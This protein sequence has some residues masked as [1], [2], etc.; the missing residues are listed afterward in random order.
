MTGEWGG[1]H[2][3]LKLTESGGTLIYDCAAGTMDGPLRLD[4]DGRF[5]AAGLHTPA[6]AEPEVEGQAPPAYRV[7]YGG[8]ARGKRMRLYG[9]VE[10]GVVLGPF[11]LRRDAA[12]DFSACEPR[13]GRVTI[14]QP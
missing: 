14:V 1:K 11:S 7:R 4:A 13:K 8:Q 5:S 2:A 12:P 9:R 10:N 6:S 3:Q